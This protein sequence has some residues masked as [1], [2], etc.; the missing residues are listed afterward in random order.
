MF[1]EFNMDTGVLVTVPRY[2]NSES[3]WA[4]RVLGSLLGNSHNASVLSGKVQLCLQT[5]TQSPHLWASRGDQG[6]VGLSSTPR[7]PGW[8]W[9]QSGKASWRR[10]D[11]A[12]L[13]GQRRFTQAE[14][15]ASSPKSFPGTTDRAG[16]PSQADLGLNPWMDK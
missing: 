6:S 9:G 8:A 13:C 10:D 15:A 3:F 11:G 4:I 2:V 7:H 5:G 12:G 1:T 16:L 14:R